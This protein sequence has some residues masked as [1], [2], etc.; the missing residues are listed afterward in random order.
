ME[1]L[2]DPKMTLE[3]ADWKCTWW[4]AIDAG[5]YPTGMVSTWLHLEIAAVLLL[6]CVKRTL[7][8]RPDSYISITAWLLFRN[9][10]MWAPFPLCVSGFLPCAISITTVR[11]ILFKRW[12]TQY[13][14]TCT[15]SFIQTPP[16]VEVSRWWPRHH[17][18]KNI[19]WVCS[20]M[21]PITWGK[22]IS[23]ISSAL[24]PCRCAEG[25][26]IRLLLFSSPYPPNFP[27]LFWGQKTN[28]WAYH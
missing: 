2:K 20:L 9:G 8:L 13:C 17:N 5:G 26:A 14:Y 24:F 19:D 7:E 22:S 10:T 18:N 1:G 15:G 12:Y 23:L 21:R 27:T 6:Y 3:K 11:T 25:W 28:L 4:E 16:H